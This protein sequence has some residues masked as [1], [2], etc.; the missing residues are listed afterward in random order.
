MN[1]P[2]VKGF[3]KLTYFCNTDLSVNENISS[4]LIDLKKQTR[5]KCFV[6]RLIQHVILGILNKSSDSSVPKSI[7]V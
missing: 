6:F 4:K 7:Y 3:I 1:F 2:C 5:L